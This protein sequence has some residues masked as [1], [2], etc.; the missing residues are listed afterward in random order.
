M[1]P[2]SGCAK[3]PRWVKN[4]VVARPTYISLWYLKQKPSES[5]REYIRRCRQVEDKIE[6]LPTA[7]I[8]TAFYLNVRSAR[9]REAMVARWVHTVADL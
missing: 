8:I 6:G 7:S 2:P 4:L 9:V 3:M 5:L 1:V